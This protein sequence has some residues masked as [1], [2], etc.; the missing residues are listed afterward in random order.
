MRIKVS[1]AD[2]SPL[3]LWAYENFKEHY[4]AILIDYNTIQ[5]MLINY[6]IYEI[7]ED[8]IDLSYANEHGFKVEALF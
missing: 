8:T 5:G 1:S 7:K 4:N 2:G 6:I 3:H